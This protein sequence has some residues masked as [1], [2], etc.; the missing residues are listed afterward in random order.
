V[1]GLI[2]SVAS[3]TAGS[4]ITAN[5]IRAAAID[6]DMT[7]RNIPSMMAAGPTKA[8]ARQAL[9]APLGRFVQAAVVAGT[10]AYLIR[11]EAAAVSGQ[12]LILD[13]WGIQQ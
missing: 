6:P 9:I 4:G 13:G 7:D 10:M 2:R 5:C 12:S 1:V 8:Q 3:E 11:E